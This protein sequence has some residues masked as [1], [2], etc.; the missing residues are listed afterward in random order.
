[1]GSNDTMPLREIIRSIE[2]K[3]DEALRVSQ[4]YMSDSNEFKTKVLESLAEIKANYTNTRRDIDKN[5]DKI[6]GL[7]K[8]DRN[9]KYLTVGISGLMTAIGAIF[10]KILHG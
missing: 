1:M 5:T 9:Q 4:N 7:E 3:N 2:R 8:S 10:N 6:E